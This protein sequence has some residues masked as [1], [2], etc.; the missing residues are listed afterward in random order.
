MPDDRPLTPADPEELLFSLSHALQY[1]GKRHFKRADGFMARIVAEHLAECLRRS[2]YVIMK[3]PPLE[4]H[5]SS[6][7]LGNS[8]T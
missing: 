3:R 8:R 2:G 1:D 5:S 4:A 6:E 7:G